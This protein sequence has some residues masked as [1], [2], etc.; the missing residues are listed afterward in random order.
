MLPPPP[1]L[2]DFGRSSRRTHERIRANFNRAWW[3]SLIGSGVLVGELT[4]RY[5]GLSD[6]W[7]LLL[8]I[9][10]VVTPWAIVTRMRRR[11]FQRFVDYEYERRAS[12]E[13]TGT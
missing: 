13:R 10:L 6:R 11:A 4:Q 3:W 9:A 5:T 7:M 8:G 12:A 2:L 1:D